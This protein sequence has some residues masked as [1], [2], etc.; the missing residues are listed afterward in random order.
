MKPVPPSAG[1]SG[2]LGSARNL[3]RDQLG[4]YARAMATHGDIARF[5]VGPPRI[6]FTFDTVF[7]P[8]GARRVLAADSEHYV[9]D[10]PVIGEFRY[11][12]GDGLLVSKGDRWRSHRRVAQPLFTRRAVK[13]HLQP[14]ATA[15]ADLVA[16]CEAEA[17][18][19]GAVD[20]H[21]LSMRYALHA[22][23]HTVFG[24][25][26][27]EVAPTLRD[28]LPP[29]GDHLKRRSL[30]PLRSPHWW[31]SP[32]NR[33]AE[34]IRKVVWDLADA[35]I[36]RRR[37]EGAHGD[38]LLSR[39]LAARD[40]E[41]GQGLTDADVRDEAIIF[42]IAGHETTGSALAFTLFLLGRHPEVQERVRDEAGEAAGDEYPPHYD[43]DRLPYTVQVLNEAMRLYPPAHTVVRRASAE[44]ELLGYPVDE[45]RILAVSIWGIHHRSTVWSDPSTFS[46]D[47]FATGQ[48][49]GERSRTASGYS[50]LPFGG[51]PRACIGEHLAMAELVAAVAAVVRRYRLHSLLDSPPLEVDLALR[52]GGSLPCRLEPVGATT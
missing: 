1:G 2:L 10:A 28:V 37:A 43:P 51:G 27:V 32:A 29:L 26:I 4:T 21:Q 31:P 5:R 3:Q 24:D 17:G 18:A 13:T 50:H 48:A 12:L 16:W 38:D 9:K 34:G 6:G 22:L 41:T 14:I 25:D 45:G 52:P 30:A 20:L 11:F 44:T 46:P 36:A 39:L 19:G 15:A 7:T 33:R 40:P 8:E 23:G 49:T 47:R 42:L 35:L